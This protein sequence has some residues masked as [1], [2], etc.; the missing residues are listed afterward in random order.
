MGQR[1]DVNGRM[2]LWVQNT[3]HS[4]KRVVNGPAVTAVTGTLTIPNV[5]AGSYRVEWWN[6]YATSSPI[7][8]TQ[9]VTSNG[10]LVLTLPAALADDVAVKIYKN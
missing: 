9:T 3:Q 5:P 6:T 8:L 4:W 2:R 7:F 10:S 1:D